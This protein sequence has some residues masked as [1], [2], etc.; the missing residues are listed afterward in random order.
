M[1]KRFID[2]NIFRKGYMRAIPANVKLF[3]IYLFCECDHYGIWSVELDVAEVRLCITLDYQYTKDCLKEKIVEMDGGRKWFLPQFITF[4]YGTLSPKHKLHRSVLNELQRLDLMRHVTLALQLPNTD[5]TVKDKEMDK[6]KDKEMDKEME[7]DKESTGIGNLHQKPANGSV[8]LGIRNEAETERLGDELPD[9]WCNASNMGEKLPRIA[10][11]TEN[12]ETKTRK[13]KGKASSAS[14]KA[15]STGVAGGAELKQFIEVYHA[16]SKDK[17]I[18][19][20]FTAADGAAMKQIVK[21]LK[22]IDSVQSGSKTPLEVWN[23]ILTNWNTLNAWMQT[24]VQ[25]RQINSQLPNIIEQIRQHYGQSK[26]TAKPSAVADFAKSLRN[27]I[28]G[29]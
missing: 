29:G 21:Y 3:Y 23:F 15:E 6:D 2:S 28:K 8:P 14:Q 1:A 17:G 24:Q 12:K 18:M 10:E 9:G 27:A 13:T 16:W 22:G 5:A 20:R 4:Q 11:I 19:F 7:M 26:Q 25:V